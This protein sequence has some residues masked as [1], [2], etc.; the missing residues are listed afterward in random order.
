[1]K[2]KTTALCTAVFASLL[3]GVSAITSYAETLNNVKAKDKSSDTTD[4]SD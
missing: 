2:R 3:M 1:M 4:S